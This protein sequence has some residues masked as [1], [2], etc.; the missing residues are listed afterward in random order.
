M[1]K[2]KMIVD[3]FNK[4]K[5]WSNRTIAQVLGVS[6]R[7]V[8][9]VLNPI[10]R[11]QQA[12]SVKIKLPKILLFDIETLP[13]SVYVWFLGKQR[14]HPQNITDE[15]SV[16][17]WSAKWLFE[18]E[19]MS[20]VVTAKEA[21][22]RQ[23]S[24]I[25]QGIWDL[26]D[27][28]DIVVAQNGDR[29]D[30]RKLNTRFLKYGYIPPS[31][32]QSIDTLKVMQRYFSL[33][34][35][36]LDYVA[37]FLGFRPKKSTDF[38]LWKDCLMG[39]EEA[40]NFMVEYNRNDVMMLEDLYLKIRGWI[41]SH[42]NCALYMETVDSVCANCGSNNIEEIGRYYTQAGRYASFRC[43]DCGAMCRSRYA[44][45]DKEERRALLA[46]SAK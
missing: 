34:S 4:H 25:L 23:D 40:L 21:I 30:I 32:Y 42:P 16:V 1:H 7:Y 36:K 10:R 18:P 11:G 22:K 5:S 12:S 41:K 6:R 44:D 26:L 3:T 27:Q 8:R 31:S 38:S 37:K 2:A 45:L 29:F 14:I 35:Y 43:L 39:K 19:V 46:S 28:A 33:P 24:S 15:W 9:R 13:M 20:Q 17:S